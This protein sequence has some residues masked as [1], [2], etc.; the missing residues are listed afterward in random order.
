MVPKG[1]G[2]SPEAGWFR[3]PRP[4]VHVRAEGVFE[5]EVYDHLAVEFRQV[6]EDTR[7]GR[8]KKAVFR[9]PANNYDAWICGLDFQSAQLFFPLFEQA[10]LGYLASLLD[11]QDTG[12][13]D[14]ALH[15][16]PRDSRSGYLHTDFCSAWFDRCNEQDVVRFPMRGL[17]DYFTGYPRT[18]SAHPVE[19]IRRAT[20]IFYLANDNWADGDGGETGLFSSVSGR[21]PKALCPPRDNSLL[22][23]ECMPHSFHALQAS[24]RRERNSI[25]LWL[26]SDVARAQERW[27]TGMTRRKCS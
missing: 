3:C 9:P 10:W 27:P 6:L 22:L 19:C 16:V 14:G 23:F 24:S 4:F 20:M 5:R 11:L 26:H 18:T 13:V 7:Q 17:T 8:T 1:L 2:M 25:I 15:H 12:I 21:G